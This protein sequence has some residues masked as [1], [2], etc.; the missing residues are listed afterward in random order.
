M[1]RALQEAGAEQ[2]EAE[3]AP[4]GR[5]AELGCGGGRGRQQGPSLELAHSLAQCPLEG[6]QLPAPQ[7]RLLLFIH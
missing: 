6:A 2:E 7:A 3:E 1:A 5:G 4:P